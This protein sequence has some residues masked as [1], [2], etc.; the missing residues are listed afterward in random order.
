MLLLLSLLLLV[1]GV[2]ARISLDTVFVGDPN[3]NADTTGMGSVG[4]G[5]HIETCEVRNTQYVAFLNAKA[6]TD[7]HGIYNTW[8]TRADHAGLSRSGSSGSSTYT[9]KSGFENKPMNFVDF[10]LA[11]RFA[12]WLSNGQGTGETENG[13]YN[14]NR[15][16]QPVNTDIACDVAIWSTGGVAIA[17]ENE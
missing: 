15:V 11:A 2:N 13:V 4:Y 3:N 10:R 17:S 1:T 7:P 8:M 6:T 16:S 14:L 12:N 9:V 5:Y